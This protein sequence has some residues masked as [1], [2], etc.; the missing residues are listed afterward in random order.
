[1]ILF[2]SR[3]FTIGI[4]VTHRII[5]QKNGP[6]TIQLTLFVRVENEAAPLRNSFKAAAASVVLLIIIIGKRCFVGIL[7]LFCSANAMRL[8]HCCFLHKYSHK[9]YLTAQ[10]IVCVFLFSAV[11]RNLN[12]FS[13]FDIFRECTAVYQRQY[14]IIWL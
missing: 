4:N 12:I 1:M 10:K 2:I 9:A 7:L 14:H 3:C 13:S 11:S 6:Q 8:L 5:T